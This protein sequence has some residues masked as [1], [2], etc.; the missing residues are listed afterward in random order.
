MAIDGTPPFK[1]P[2]GAQP[3]VLNDFDLLTSVQS[4]AF[5]AS[6]PYTVPA[7][8]RLVISGAYISWVENSATPPTN[9]REILI[10][11]GSLEADGHP[12][13]GQVHTI[14]GVAVPPTQFAQVVGTV[15]NLAL[16]IP[17]G[18]S[19]TAG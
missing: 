17:A 11:V 19:I 1:L 18:F 7:G 13:A 15:T 8:K 9:G 14:H 2:P 4:T 10:Q 5:G 6:G 12:V 3:I 16:P